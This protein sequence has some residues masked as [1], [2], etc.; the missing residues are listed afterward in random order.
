[1]QEKFVEE[2]SLDVYPTTKAKNAFQIRISSKPHQ[3]KKTLS[4]V[5]ISFFM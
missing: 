1:M 4:V 5:Q 2:A 3:I